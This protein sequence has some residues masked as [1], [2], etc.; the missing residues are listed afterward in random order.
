MSYLLGHSLAT[1]LDQVGEQVSSFVY[2]A[3]WIILHAFLSSVF[4]K[5]L[6]CQTVWIQIRSIV[7][8]TNCSLVCKGYQQ[9]P[10]VDVSKERV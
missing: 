6:Q 5:F 9:T 8:D 10:K 7:Q 3:Y 4:K 1:E 2:F